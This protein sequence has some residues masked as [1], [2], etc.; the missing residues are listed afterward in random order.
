M[1]CKI[2]RAV[3]TAALLHLVFLHTYW[4]TFLVSEQS[5]AIK[6]WHGFIESYVFAYIVG[7]NGN[8]IHPQFSQA[9]QM[10]AG[11]NSTSMNSLPLILPAALNASL[12]WNSNNSNINSKNNNLMNN[13]DNGRGKSRNI[14]DVNMNSN[15]GSTYN[16][17]NADF[18]DTDT[19]Q[20]TSSY[21]QRS[22]KKPNLATGSTSSNNLLGKYQQTGK[23]VN[24]HMLTPT[25]LQQIQTQSQSLSNINSNGTS[26]SDQGAKQSNAGI[27]PSSS[28]VSIAEDKQQANRDRNREHARNTRLRKK[29]YLEKLKVTVDEL[30]RERDSLLQERTANANRVLETLATRT[31]VIL[32]FLALRQHPAK[33]LNH[34][35]WNSLISEHSFQFLLPVTPYRSFP[36]AEVSMQCCRR[37]LHGIEALIADCASLHM[38]FN[39]LLALPTESN[40]KSDQK[41]YGEDQSNRVSF[42]YSIITENTSKTATTHSVPSD[43]KF[44]PNSVQSSQVQMQSPSN[45]VSGIVCNNNQ[46]MARWQMKTTNLMKFG[47]SSEVSKGGMVRSKVK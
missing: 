8:T 22:T 47:A 16:G 27:V 29:A 31:E 28:L 32:G 10:N 42:Q 7:Q 14:G 40:S 44:L 26:S 11:N 30:C 24:S 1:G 5:N 12:P 39:S 18:T 13:K 9:Q 36:A 45:L 3:T 4:Q 21:H 17:E 35:L 25:N 20:T 15:R 23:G 6:I 33:H 46:M 34:S 38:M 37:T 19:S 43:G 2:Y 41:Y